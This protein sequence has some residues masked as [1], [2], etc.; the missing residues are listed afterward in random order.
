MVRGERS[1]VSGKRPEARGQRSEVRGQRS[2]VRRQRS[3]SYRAAITHLVHVTDL[4]MH[5]HTYACTCT[6]HLVHV[7]A[8]MPFIA[9]PLTLWLPTTYRKQR[10]FCMHRPRL[11]PNMSTCHHAYPSKRTRQVPGT[12][13]P[14]G[15]VP[16][17]MHHH[18]QHACTRALWLR[19]A[20]NDRALAGNDRGRT[21]SACDTNS[22]QAGLWLHATAHLIASV[23]DAPQLL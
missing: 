7:T 23:H 13:P 12:R 1:Q 15:K 10:G 20:G 22:V 2:E 5:T 18:G 9:Q 16:E 4:C 17:D 11:V 14:S 19:L 8:P 21:R 6:P 3:A